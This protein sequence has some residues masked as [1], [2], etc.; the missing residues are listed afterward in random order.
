MSSVIFRKSCFVADLIEPVDEL[1]LF[2]GELVAVGV[3]EHI[4]EA[5]VR[6]STFAL[7]KSVFSAEAFRHGRIKHEGLGHSQQEVQ[8][9]S[10]VVH[11]D[12][13]YRDVGRTI[14]GVEFFDGS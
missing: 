8:S 1:E 14:L 3:D 4:L 7:D 13:L 2:F 11:T 10:T 12:T 5:V 9:A 6:K